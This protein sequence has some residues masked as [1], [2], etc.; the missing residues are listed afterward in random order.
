MAGHRT[1]STRRRSF[2]LIGFTEVGFLVA[3]TGWEG[4]AVSRP[5]VAILKHSPSIEAYHAF[6]HENPPD[7]KSGILVWLLACAGPLRSNPRAMNW[8]VQN[9]WLIPALPLLAAGLSALS[10]AERRQ[11]VAHGV[12]RG[13]RVH[14]VISSVGAIE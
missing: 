4:N 5:D 8:A 12:S 1:A 6:T 2:V 9:L 7:A 10:G 14:N 11:P 3:E 13:I